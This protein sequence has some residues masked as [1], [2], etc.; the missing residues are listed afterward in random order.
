MKVSRVD[1]AILRKGR[2]LK[3]IEF[4]KL[5]GDTLVEVASRFGVTLSDLEKKTGLSV[6]DLVYH[7]EDTGVKTR[8]EIGFK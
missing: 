3:S 4:T 7:D 5:T 8:E 6:A 1:T 2:L